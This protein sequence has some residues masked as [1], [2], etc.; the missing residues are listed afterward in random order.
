M[1]L[2]LNHFL[3]QAEMLRKPGIFHQIFPRYEN[4]NFLTDSTYTL[5]Q[6]NRS[7]KNKKYEKEKKMKKL[8]RQR[9]EDRKEDR[10][11][12]VQKETSKL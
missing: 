2:L 8:T 3:D 12:I 11:C 5:K 9:N 1:K 6:L 10:R 4:Y 7:T